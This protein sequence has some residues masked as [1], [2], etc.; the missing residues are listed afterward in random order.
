MFSAVSGS[1]GHD[2]LYQALCNACHVRQW[3]ALL[4]LEDFADLSSSK[5]E[6]AAALLSSDSDAAMAVRREAF[7]GTET[8]GAS[9]LFGTKL[10]LEA[11]PEGR[12]SE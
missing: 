5:F 1:T 12:A 6:R 9:R 8:T 11:E 2:E 10:A 3:L 7:S 4:A